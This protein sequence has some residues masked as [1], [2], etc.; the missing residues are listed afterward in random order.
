MRQTRNR[1]KH[2]ECYQ[3]DHQKPIFSVQFNRFAGSANIFATVADN[4]VTVY[5]IKTN[6]HPILCFSDPSPN[7]CFYCCAWTVDID[8]GEYI[9]L[10]AGQNGIIRVISLKHSGDNK[11][12]PG[13]GGSINDIRISPIDTN[14]VLTASKDHS[15]RLW[16]LKTETCIAIFGG[17]EGHRD[18]VLSSDFHCSGT[19]IVSC[20]MDHS[21]KI[22]NFDKDILNAIALSRTFNNRTAKVSFPTE[23]KHFA[24]YSTREIHRN[25]VD[26]VSWFGNFILSKSCE[27]SIICWKP[28]KLETATDIKLPMKY[29]TDTSSTI[30]ESLVTKDC[31]IW[32]IRFSIDPSMRYLALGNKLGKT[33]VFDLDNDEYDRYVVFYG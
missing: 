11:Y 2:V 15:L 9:L 29:T 27:N 18:E 14:L 3:E 6:I 25:Y 31:D 33:Y 19:K 16:N 1:Y 23:K 8:E 20:G 24:T 30:L 22:W 17:V 12:L 21:L 13:H 7:E 4:R 5:E 28:G 32:F 26:C 10:A